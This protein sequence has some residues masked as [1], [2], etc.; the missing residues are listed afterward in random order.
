[1]SKQYWC[2]ITV[3]SAQAFP[4]SVL[5]KCYKACL[6]LSE[7][8]AVQL[9][10]LCDTSDSTN[11]VYLCKPLALMALDEGIVQRGVHL[12]RWTSCENWAAMSH[13]KIHVLKYIEEADSWLHR[14]AICYE[15]E[16]AFAEEDPDRYVKLLAHASGN[17]AVEAGHRVFI[18]STQMLCGDRFGNNLSTN[19]A[20]RHA[21]ANTE[22]GTKLIKR[23]DA[24]ALPLNIA[25]LMPPSQGDRCIFIP[26]SINDESSNPFP[27]VASLYTV[28]S[29]MITADAKLVFIGVHNQER[30]EFAE[31]AYD[32]KCKK[33][34]FVQ[35]VPV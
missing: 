8:Y 1:M 16:K 13:L 33:D 3:S 4:I 14:W 9:D 34:R 5:S 27:P 10:L 25:H 20:Q 29:R 22:Q 18:H 30:A 24:Y 31:R 28:V 7:G 32:P 17:D 11:G 23:L 35:N 2:A 6:C 21:V 12:E 26:R 19:Q 15:S